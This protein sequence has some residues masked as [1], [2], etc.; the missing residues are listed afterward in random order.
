MWRMGSAWPSG[1]P[2]V[3]GLIAVSLQRKHDPPI[4]QLLGKLRLR[5]A[6]IKRPEPLQHMELFACHG[7]CF[8][9]MLTSSRRPGIC[10][11]V[12]IGHRE[13]A[14]SPASTRACKDEEAS[15][16]VVCLTG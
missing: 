16:S 8:E 2:S 7:S 12:P 14:A 4:Q 11:V 13:G 6:A 5:S 10:L 9:S 15:H 3:E 1:R